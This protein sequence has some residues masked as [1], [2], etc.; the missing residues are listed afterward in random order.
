M[1]EIIGVSIWILLGLKWGDWRNWSNYQSTFVYFIFCDVLYYYITYTHPLWTLEPTWPLKTKLICIF[2]EFIVF[3]ST[4]L[5]FLG[6]YPTNR[7][8]STWWTFMWVIIYTVNEWILLKLG[9]F[10]YHH[11]WGLFHSFLFN[12]LLF[13]ML[14]LYFK[15]PVGALLL[16]LPIIISLIYLTSI[17][18]K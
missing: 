15:K 1:A 13:V 6:N 18:V 9:V 12:I 7:L 3:A 5:I 4:V 11:N 16:T 17:P 10:S 14:R 2:G 8:F